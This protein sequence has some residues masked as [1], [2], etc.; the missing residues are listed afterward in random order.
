MASLYQGSWKTK[1]Y[2][3]GK[4]SAGLGIGRG[5]ET[6]LTYWILAQGVRAP[7]PRVHGVEAARTKCLVMHGG[8]VVV[9]LVMNLWCSVNKTFL[10][11]V[12]STEGGKGPRT[13]EVHPEGQQVG[14]VSF[15]WIQSTCRITAFLRSAHSGSEC[16]L[17][18]PELIC[19]PSG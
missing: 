11:T 6:V 9:N 18:V 8:T 13:H 1:F 14:M 3:T 15:L 16:G 17:G 7:L 5:P 2:Q 19:F 12:A 10:S 4:N